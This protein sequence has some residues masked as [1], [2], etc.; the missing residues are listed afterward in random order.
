MKAMSNLE[1]FDKDGKEVHIADVI[2]RFIEI[3]AIENNRHELDIYVKKEN[4]RIEVRCDDGC[5]DLRFTELE[6]I[7]LNR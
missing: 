3:K 1:I 5:S 6:E 4:N 7:S 2:S